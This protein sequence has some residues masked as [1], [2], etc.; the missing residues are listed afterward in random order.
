MVE[1]IVTFVIKILTPIVGY[2]FSYI[3]K[4]QKAKDALIKAVEKYQSK[5]V[6]NT[7]DEDKESWEILEDEKK[8]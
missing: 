5:P 8:N 1:A 4:N 6:D 7:L 2:I 3:E